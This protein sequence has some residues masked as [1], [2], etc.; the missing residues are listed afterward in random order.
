[1]EE[2]NL[3]VIAAHRNSETEPTPTP[4]FNIGFKSEMQIKHMRD[5]LKTSFVSTLDRQVR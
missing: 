5:E 2:D 4:K 3:R 1:M